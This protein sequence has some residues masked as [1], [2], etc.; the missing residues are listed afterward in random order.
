MKRILFVAPSG[1]FDNGAEIAIFHLI[2]LLKQQGNHIL[3]AA[4]ASFS[5][6]EQEYRSRYEKIDVPVFFLE[7]QK[8]WW[9][10]APGALIGTV[11]ERADSYRQNIHEL[12]E[13]IEKNQVELVVTNTVNMFQ[14]AVAA[15]CEEIP[16]YWL[17]HEFPENEFAY[18]LDKIDFIQAT[19]DRVFAVYG[20]LAT[21]L[22]ELFEADLGTFIPYTEMSPQPLTTGAK[23]RLVS[24]GRLS[25]RKN[26]LALL[27]AYQAL[28]DQNLEL[29][30]IGP[31]DEAYKKQLDNYIADHQL[32]GV[33]FT[34]GQ[35][36]PWA[37]VTD[38]DICVFP[39]N[40]E[41]F[42]LVYAEALL[43]GVPVILS[44]NPGHLSAYEYFQF[45][46]VYPLGD[47]ARLASEIQQVM[48]DFNQESE[49]AQAF[50]P[51]AKELYQPEKVYHEIVQ[52]IAQQGS[53][54]KPLRHL[55]NI[56]TYNEERGR[57]A[58]FEKRFYRFLNRVRA[59]FAR[60][61]QQ[62]TQ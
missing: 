42:G 24:V 13:L 43:R 4:P 37:S 31:W 60:K 46:H 49:K 58:R 32:Q 14:G 12:R 29:C 25:E 59:W 21:R 47:E 57:L 30:F 6:I 5:K 40:M 10:D 16:H 22:S 41:T 17:I 26:Q 28:N 56:V 36:Q 62:N 38:Q 1:T 50:A 20:K 53:T 33:H 15:A 2:H 39:S 51:K 19:G 44:D 8:W 54:K 3:V 61:K 34:G 18:Y 7:R 55:G 27:Q 52:A 23:R 45:G 11:G 9:E 35:E 48:A